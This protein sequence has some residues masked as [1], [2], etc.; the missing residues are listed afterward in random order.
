MSCTVRQIRSAERISLQILDT[1]PCCSSTNKQKV[2]S[3]VSTKASHGK[4]RKCFPRNGDLVG[5]KIVCFSKN[6]TQRN[7]VNNVYCTSRKYR[8]N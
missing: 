3:S 4:L 1:L 2:S 8:S 7:L 5:S 6:A